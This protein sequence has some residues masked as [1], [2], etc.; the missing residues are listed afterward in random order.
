MINH[1]FRDTLD[2]GMSAFM[3]DIIMW[4]QTIEELHDRT[5]KVLQRLK[6]NR[7]YIARD[8]CKWA[9]HQMEFLGY[10][11]SGKGIKMTDE[12]V[13]T[14][15]KIELVQSLMDVQ[16]FL[17]FTNFYQSFIKDYSKIIL[18][19]TNSISLSKQEWQSTPEIE[20][21]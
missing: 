16:H 19:M 12:K 21:A 9:Q 13:E 15:K 20:Q 7:L 17:E 11:V 6:E 8:K 4:A 10:M 5:I 3:D 2:Q 1:I 18:P 14:I